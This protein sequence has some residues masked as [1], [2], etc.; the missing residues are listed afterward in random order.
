MTFASRDPL[1]KYYPDRQWITTF[2]HL[3]HEF[4]DGGELNQFTRLPVDWPLAGL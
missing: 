4:A 2:T 1:T 3:N